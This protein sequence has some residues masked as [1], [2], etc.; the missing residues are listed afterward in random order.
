MQEVMIDSVDTAESSKMERMLAAAGATGML[1]GS[2]AVWYFDPTK[3][4]FFP[5]CPLYSLTG[6]ACPGCGM[7]RGLHAFL[8]G[9]IA[10]ALGYNALLPLFL[11]LFGFGFLTLVSYAVRGRRLAFSLFSANALW[12]LFILLIVFGV[13]RNL[14]FYPFT[15]LFP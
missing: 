4:D 12:P 14:P 9:D 5:V 10:T 6:F 2:A 1:V 11:V 15:L 8:H 13:L 7:T 3:A